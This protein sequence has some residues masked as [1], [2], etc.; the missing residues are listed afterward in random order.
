MTTL[1]RRLF[2]Q[3][4]LPLALLV[5]FT[6]SSCASKKDGTSADLEAINALHQRDMEA[7]KKWDVDTLVSLWSDDIVTLTQGE[8]PVIG[9]DANR[10]AISRLREESS[11]VQITDYILSFNEVKIVGDWAFEWGTYS[12]TVKP[13]AGGDAIRTT[14]KVIRVLKKDTDGSWK[15]AR[16][17]YDSDAETE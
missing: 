7:S 5:S 1:A 9:K 2:N 11:E 6:A 8:P 14:G 13:V 10:A 17:M 16:A 12:G 15:I 4:L 3:T